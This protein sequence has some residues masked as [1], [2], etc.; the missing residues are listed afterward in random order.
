MKLGESACPF[1]YL[2]WNFLITNKTLLKSN[3]RMAIPYHTLEHMAQDQR[4]EILR[5]AGNFLAGFFY[6]R[7]PGNSTANIHFWLF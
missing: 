1:N 5:N 6:L 4:E 2:Y 7:Y 3:P